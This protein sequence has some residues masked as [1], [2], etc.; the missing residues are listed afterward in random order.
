MKVGDVGGLRY[1]VPGAPF[2]FMY[3]Y[4]EGPKGVRPVGLREEAVAPFGPRTMPRPWTGRKP[5][6]KK[7]LPEFDS[8]KPPPAGKK[9]VKPVQKPGPYLPGTGPRYVMSRDEVLGEELTAE[10]VKELVE[11]CRKSKR[12]LNMGMLLVSL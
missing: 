2:E 12:Q 4:T 5:L 7:Q 1:V 8:F 10:E 11:G 9:G 3:S 6:S